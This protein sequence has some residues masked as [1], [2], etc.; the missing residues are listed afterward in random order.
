MPLNTNTN[1][2][3]GG[4]ASASS[5]RASRSLWHNFSVTSQGTLKTLLSGMLFYT[6]HQIS[7]HFGAAAA[8]VRF[9]VPSPQQLPAGDTLDLTLPFDMFGGLDDDLSIKISLADGQPLPDWIEETIA[10]PEVIGTLNL[11]SPAGKVFVENDRAYILN[12]GGISVVNLTDLTQPEVMGRYDGSLSGQVTAMGV[13]DE[14]A[15]GLL[16]SDKVVAINFRNP[17]NP[18]KLGNGWSI[19]GPNSI[20]LWNNTA[21]VRT[22]NAI[23]SFDITNSS[24]LAGFLDSLPVSAE[25]GPI[26][27]D[28]G[29]GYTTTNDE[30]VLSILDIANPRNISEIGNIPI[31][32]I[33]QISA[34]GDRAIT[35]GGL[36][37]NSSLFNILNVSDPR[38]MDRLG[39]YTIDDAV[40]DLAINFPNNLAWLAETDGLEALHFSDPQNMETAVFL[41]TAQSASGIAILGNAAVMVSSGGSVQTLDIG[42]RLQGVAHAGTWTIRVQLVDRSG[43]VQATSNFTIDV[44]SM[45]PTAVPSL[46]PSARPSIGPSAQPVL[47]PSMTPLRSTSL[48]PTDFPTINPTLEPT[49]PPNIA[50]NTDEPTVNPTLEPTIHPIAAKDTDDPTVNPTFEPTPNPSAV[51]GT[52]NPTNNPIPAPTAFTPTTA[53]PTLDPT[54][55]P[56]SNPFN[57]QA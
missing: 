23:N 56:T 29:R 16:D 30:N 39:N 31:G 24:G 25:A 47:A 27:A 54:S 20:A 50:M 42:R 6:V 34:S 44:V 36:D 48:R 37:R 41:P 2:T 17:G 32:D 19:T 57:V 8:K 5:M 45:N 1:K 46:S 18:E 21:F 26:A 11:A 52:D 15:Y 10:G 3:S 38:H 9:P 40:N 12:N 33:S 53:L 7:S 28:N 51:K 43:A 49:I 22:Q 4:P 14:I 13:Q 55:L 35:I